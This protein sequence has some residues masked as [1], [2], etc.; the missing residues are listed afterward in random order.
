MRA[1]QKATE[2]LTE[3]S[4]ASQVIALRYALYDAL[5]RA[6]A[7]EERS[8]DLEHQLDE[9]RG[10]AEVRAREHQAMAAKSLCDL[11]AVRKECEQRLGA[12]ERIH[13]ALERQCTMLE[14]TCRVLFLTLEQ[15]ACAELDE[16]A[17]RQA[18]TA[19]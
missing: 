13:A 6:A 4:A 11:V 5:R 9:E 16:D 1:F 15:A 10:E 3:H 8:Q 14:E 7:L 12:L 17:R 18:R 2:G 19:H